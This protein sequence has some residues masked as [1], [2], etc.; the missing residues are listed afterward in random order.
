MAEAEG[1]P[2]H[3]YHHGDLKRALVDEAVRAIAEDGLNVLS[4]RDLARR[5]GVSHA[6]P[7]YH[8]GDKTGLLTAVAAEGFRLLG[9]ELQAAGQREDGFL[10][11]SLAYVRFAVRQ[12][13]YFQVMFGYDLHR[14]ADP[15]LAEERARV[16]ELLLAPLDDGSLEGVADGPIP[17][18]AAWSL[19]HGLASLIVSGNLPA[20]LGD[21]TDDI[22]RAVLDNALSAEP[23]GR[24]T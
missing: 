13:P 11:L 20:V 1:A 14:A 2:E 17:G 6:A 24:S 22:V 21:R 12:Q 15:E 18:T 9:E 10:G 16:R 5:V 8:F 4:L 23:F 7:A 3:A 19:V